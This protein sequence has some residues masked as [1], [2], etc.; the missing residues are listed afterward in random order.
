MSAAICAA[1]SIADARSSAE[2]SSHISTRAC[3]ESFGARK[4]PHE[5]SAPG[6]MPA[7]ARMYIGSCK[8]FH[9]PFAVRCSLLANSP[10]TLSIVL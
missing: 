9:S 3:D 5:I 2:K 4:Y 6:Y 10:E 8:F 1:L 7:A